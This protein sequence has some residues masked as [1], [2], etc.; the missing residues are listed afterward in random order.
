M[1]VIPVVDGEG[2]VQGVVSRAR[3]NNYLLNGNPPSP[4]EAVCVSPEEYMK[5]EERILI[6]APLNIVL[7]VSPQKTLH[8][9]LRSEMREGE[10]EQSG[11]K[12]P[13]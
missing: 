6:E 8:D 2:L 9:L 11:G 7:L 12:S 3:L 13:E 5:T 10:A 4:Q 1:A